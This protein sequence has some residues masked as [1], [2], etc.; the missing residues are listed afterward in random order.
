MLSLPKFMIFLHEVEQI[1]H[2]RKRLPMPSLV[3]ERKFQTFGNAAVSPTG[4]CAR[5]GISDFVF[6]KG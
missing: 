2:L 1:Y 6:I 4:P 5:S 3:T